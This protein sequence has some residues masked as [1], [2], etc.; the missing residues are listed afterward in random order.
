MA[1]PFTLES[2]NKIAARAVKPNVAFRSGPPIEDSNDL[3]RILRIPRRHLD[4]KDPIASELWTRYLRNPDPNAPPPGQCDCVKRWG[5]CINHLRTAQGWALENAMDARGLFSALGVGDGKT[6]VDILACMAIPGIERAILIIP[7]NLKAQ[8]VTRDFP[9]WAAHFKVPS[10]AGIQWYAGRP[11]LHVITYNELSLPKNSDLLKRLRPQLVIADEAQNLADPFSAR[12]GRFLRS[13]AEEPA[14][15]FCSQSGSY[16]SKSIKQ[17]AHF[18]ALSFRDN[19]PLPLDPPVVDRWALA[20]DAGDK[21]NP[22]PADPGQLLQLVGPQEEGIEN[23]Q[24]RARAAFARRLYDTLGCIATSDPDLPVGLEILERVPPTMPE[25]LKKAIS[26]TIENEQRPDEEELQTPLEVSAVTKRL[27]AGFY[28]RWRFPSVKGGNCAD[29]P[30]LVKTC[31][32]CM[33]KRSEVIEKWRAARKKWRSEVRRKCKD[34][35]EHLD[36]PNLVQH[37]AERWHLGYKFNDSGTIKEFPKFTRFNPRWREDGSGG[38]RIVFESEHWPLWN[39]LKGTV[40]HT[41]EAVWISD[42]LA[43]D[44]AQWAKEHNGIIWY[45]HDAFAHAIQK[46]C[47]EL[48]LDTPL[49]GGGLRA[50][51]DILKEKGDRAIIASVKAHGTGKNLQHAFHKN[52]ITNVFSDPRAWEQTIGRT[53]RQLQTKDVTVWT[54]RHTA[55]YR[56]AIRMAQARARFI[57]QTARNKQRL[58]IATIGWEDTEALVWDQNQEDA[59]DTP[60]PQE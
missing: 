31:P 1:D 43:K 26:N 27:S 39:T 3:Q 25:E 45:Q 19:S 57:E 32:A 2:M 7:A 44:A 23:Q 56:E 16:T 35:I 53:H 48:G 33:D 42:W 30:A 10:L 5:F 29:H 55:D 6:G 49:Y 24:E 60:G 47:K 20:L 37:A 36:S 54:Y 46:Q 58:A 38:P 34:Q 13:F 12:G 21:L 18:L 51:T 41:Q 14:L 9:Q 28:Y 59:L 50:S 8:F 11:V 4:I 40:E 22:Y 52:L 17:F 15:L